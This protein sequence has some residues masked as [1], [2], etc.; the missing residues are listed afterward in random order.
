MA[1]IKL[2]LEIPKSFKKEGEDF[3]KKALIPADEEERLRQL[4]KYQILDTE[5]ERNFD[6]ITL[7]AQHIAQKKNRFD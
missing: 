3:L 2:E 1:G 7:L 6:D 5:A 4:L